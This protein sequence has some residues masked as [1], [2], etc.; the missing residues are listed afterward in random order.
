MDSRNRFQTLIQFD[1]FWPIW[2]LCCVL[3]PFNANF[4]KWTGSFDNLISMI[5]F[6]GLAYIP[7]YF[8]LSAW[9]QEESMIHVLS[10]NW[11]V[12]IGDFF[13]KDYWS[14]IR[15]PLHLHSCILGRN[16]KELLFIHVI[17]IPHVTAIVKPTFWFIIYRKHS[18]VPEAPLRLPQYWFILPQNALM[19]VACHMRYIIERRCI[20]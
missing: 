5:I 11:W 8:S 19:D 2:P 9:H 15:Q 14:R 13:K 1:K 3:V 10:L 18:I 16:G 4:G 12:W 7:I 17:T 20:L 6:N